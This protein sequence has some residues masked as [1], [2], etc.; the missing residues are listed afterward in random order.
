MALAT[1][2]GKVEVEP[3]VTAPNAR[4][5]YRIPLKMMKAI[6]LDTKTNGIAKLNAM[7]K[8]KPGRIIPNT[9]SIVVPGLLIWFILRLPSSGRSN[10]NTE[11]A[12]MIRSPLMSVFLKIGFIVIEGFEC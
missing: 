12:A 6:L 8:R 2:I 1:T 10:N 4:P 11:K 5:M 7:P 3:F 9:K